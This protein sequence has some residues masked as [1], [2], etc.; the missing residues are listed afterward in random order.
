M[1]LFLSHCK[2]QHYL[3]LTYLETIKV[4]YNFYSMNNLIPVSLF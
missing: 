3:E 2:S 4:S 1:I